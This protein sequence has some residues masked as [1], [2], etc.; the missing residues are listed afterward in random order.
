M[1]RAV[2]LLALGACRLGFEEHRLDVDAPV[3]PADTAPLD[4]ALDGAADSGLDSTL[5]VTGPALCGMPFGTW[6]ITPPV[7]LSAVNDLLFAQ[8]PTTDRSEFDPVLSE[9]GLTLWFTTDQPGRFAVW[10]ATRPSVD[11]EFNF[12]EAMGPDV[13]AAANGHFGFQALDERVAII[14]APFAGELG[15]GDYW[16]G[17]LGASWT[18]AATALS[19]TGNDIDARLTADGLAVYLVRDTGGDRDIYRATRPDLASDFGAAVPE[20]QLNTPFSDSGPLPVAGG[21]YLVANTSVGGDENIYYAETGGPPFRLEALV[22]PTFDGEPA[23]IPRATGCEI[24]FVS[25]RDGSFDLYRA[26]VQPL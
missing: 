5:I 2:V 3:Q 20:A 22:G 12:V 15:G 8:F 7:L 24:I 17:T 13:N 9:D 10:R 19:T 23:V 11:V 21:V 4:G 18:W 26:Y 25:D 6:E 1:R 16:L 14:S